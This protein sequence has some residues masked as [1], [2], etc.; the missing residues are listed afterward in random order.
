MT[1]ASEG[2]L[3]TPGLVIAVVAVAI[4]ALLAGGARMERVA[5]IPAVGALV[6]GGWVYCA[7]GICLGPIGVHA[8]DAQRLA[9]LQPLVS[10]L[11]ALIGLIAGVQCSPAIMRAVPAR[12]VGLASLDALIALGIGAAVTL[13][14]A[15]SI[16][17]PLDLAG[18]G[19]AEGLLLLAAAMGTIVAAACG[20]A[21]ESRTLIA[22]AQP[23]AVRMAV[24]IQA[25]GGLSALIAIALS[26]VAV[27][28]L[29]PAGGG[30]MSL[31]PA[32]GAPVLVATCIAALA[33]TAIAWFLLH[34]ASRDD[35]T[36][37]VT[38]F[39]AL[40][41]VAGIA[42]AAAASPLLAGMLLGICIAQLGRRA[43][44]LLSITHASE[45][46]AAAALFLLAGAQLTLHEG[47]AI[48]VAALALATAR[49]ALKPAVV[50]MALRRERASVALESPLVRASARQSPMAVAVALTAHSVLPAPA[51][52]I[53]L[54]VIVLAGALSWVMAALPRIQR[55]APA[56]PAGLEDAR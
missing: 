2:T 25:G 28:P 42:S 19:R 9:S 56:M 8:I 54:S 39:G 13:L 22:S 27:V 34:D 29:D 18:P 55:S 50:R 16:A 5:R 23:R 33:V 51:G 36:A 52:P 15:R 10:C 4:V 21:A 32:L 26:S 20:W 41:L 1:A 49:R 6:H 14:L 53:V 46:V 17:G 47:A 12:L 30:G 31:A 35:S 3:P 37:T 38:L 24:L 40:A 11:L 48:W 45:P 44:R 43:A 7:I